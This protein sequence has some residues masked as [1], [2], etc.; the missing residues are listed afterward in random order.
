MV[1]ADPISKIQLEEPPL[2][3]LY[4]ALATDGNGLDSEQAALRLQRIRAGKPHAESGA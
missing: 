2:Q 3:A 1:S 4:P